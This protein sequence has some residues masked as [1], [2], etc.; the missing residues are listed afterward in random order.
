ML[1]KTINTVSVCI[2]AYNESDCLP[3]LLCDIEK[4]TYPHNQMEILL[5]DSGSKDDTFA[6]MENFANKPYDFLRVLTFHNSNRTL[7]H[8]CN[9]ALKNYSGD[10][11]VRIDAHAS[12]PHDFIEKNVAVLEEGEFVSGG[13]RPNIIDEQTPWKNMLLMVEQSIFGSGAAVYRHSDKKRYVSS[14]FHGMYRREVYDTVGPYNTLLSRTE[15][16]DMSYR[17]TQAGFRICYDPDIVSYQHTRNTLRKMIRQ[18]YF[19]GYWIGLTMGINPRCFSIMH[20]VPFAFV[21]A[22]LGGI[23]LSALGVSWPLLALAV[24]YGTMALLM[25]VLSVKENGWNKFAVC[26]PFLFFLLHASYGLGTLVG[27][28]KLPFWLRKIKSK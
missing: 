11:I 14:I 15:D 22:I 25:T 5:I 13:Q 19:N 17:I 18:K 2:V 27:L 28:I 10:A 8:G 12:I 4:Q 7:P 9:I 26:M 3:N 16:N 6:I 24:A 20:F 1:N 23:L 21:M